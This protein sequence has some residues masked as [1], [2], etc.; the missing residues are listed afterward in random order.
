MKCQY[1]GGNLNLQDENCPFCGRFNEQ[2]AEYTKSMKDI[3]EEYGKTAEKAKKKSKINERTARVL[4]IIFMLLIIGAM[5]IRIRLYSDFEYKHKKYNEKIEKHVAQNKEA[6]YD[7][8]KDLELRRDYLGMD[9][10]VLNY[11][12]KTDN[13]YLE[14]ARVFTAAVD[15]NAIYTDILNILDG[16]N[17][18]YKEF[19][20]EEW[21]Y[22]IA[23][24]ISNWN[25]YVEGEFWRDSA[26][27]P[28]HA[29]EH[30]AF[31]ADAKRDTQDMVQVYFDLTDEQAASM[32]TMEQ[33]EVGAM[34]Y[35]KCKILYPEVS[36][37][38]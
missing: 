28:M 10:F 38:E 8:L 23:L 5:F 13:E 3:K 25:N 27:S 17:F 2:A 15:Y 6:I 31:L 16:Q 7:M 20:K 24:Y 36:S 35:E 29:G 12:L 4:I 34:L 32:W 26:D 14:Y 37:N 18:S 33:S 21:C 19:T 11:Q 9:Y 1:C 22:N 30:G